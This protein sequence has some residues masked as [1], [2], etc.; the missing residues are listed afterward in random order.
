[1]PRSLFRMSPRK[2]ADSDSEKRAMLPGVWPGP[3]TTVSPAM[4]SPSSSRRAARAGDDEPGQRGWQSVGQAAQRHALLRP[5]WLQV[6]GV[7]LVHRETRARRL[8]ECE[9]GARVIDVVM[10]EDD[11]ID[12]AH[13][14]LLDESTHRAEAARIAR[15]DDGETFV[16]LIQIGLCAAHAGDP[17]D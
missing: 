8:A 3:W 1:M 13:A 14:S 5:A 12:R 6:R 2:S 15:V 4:V 17:T 9:R 11:P 10:R 7:S 16:A